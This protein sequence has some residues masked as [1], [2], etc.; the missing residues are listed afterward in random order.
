[1]VEDGHAMGA[2]AQILE[3]IVGA[4]EGPGLTGAA[5]PCSYRWRILPRLLFSI[6]T[7][8]CLSE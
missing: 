7:I 1:M 3:H 5:L 6:N 8:V 4:A 2:A